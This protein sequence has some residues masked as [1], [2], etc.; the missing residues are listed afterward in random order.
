MKTSQIWVVGIVAVLTLI[1]TALAGEFYSSALGGQS[2]MPAVQSPPFL[3][4][5]QYEPNPVVY[6]SG[7][8]RYDTYCVPYRSRRHVETNQDIVHASALD[9]NRGQ[10]DAGSLHYVDHYVYDE[11][12]VCY[13]EHGYRWHSNGMPHSDLSYTRCCYNG[14]RRTVT[15]NTH[16]MKEIGTESE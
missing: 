6:D 3:Q 10:V 12:G 1:G 15:D 7:R 4:Y 14:W 2:Q 8:Y 5:M 16:I 9:P 13:R 11:D